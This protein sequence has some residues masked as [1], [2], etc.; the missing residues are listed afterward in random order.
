MAIETSTQITNYKTN[1]KN[2]LNRYHGSSYGAKGL[3]HAIQKDIIQNSA[4]AVSSK[5][6]YTN[7]KVTFELIKIE[8]NFALSVTDQ[9]TTG[10][11]GGVFTN[12][13]ISGLWFF[14]SHANIKKSYTH[15][16]T[17]RCCICWTR[18]CCRMFCYVRLTRT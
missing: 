8:G 1:F 7:W 15:F 16:I 11:T 2:L 4:G 5:K 6:K 14:S 10:L 17:W 18:N 9:G 13:K 3:I 12:D